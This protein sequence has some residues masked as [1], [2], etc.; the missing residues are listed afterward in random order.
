M[1]GRYAITS[2]SGVV[3]DA[4]GPAFAHVTARY[5]NHGFGSQANVEFCGDDCGDRVFIHALRNIRCRLFCPQLP[6]LP[7]GCIRIA[8]GG[9]PNARFCLVCAHLRNANEAAAY[10]IEHVCLCM[11]VGQV[12]NCWPITASITT[13]KSGDSHAEAGKSHRHITQVPVAA[14]WLNVAQR[15]QPRPLLLSSAPRAAR[16]P[17]ATQ[18]KRS[19][20][21]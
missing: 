7:A 6:R 21:L 20:E 10:C 1:R 9:M 14:T 15:G 3:I 18:Q 4:A 17:P 16:A 12:R 8:E 11:I 2:N 19:A 13:T 5:I